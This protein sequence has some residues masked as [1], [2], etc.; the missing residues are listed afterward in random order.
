MTLTA[1]LLLSA[2]IAAAQPAPE[3]KAL[4]DLNAAFRKAYAGAKQRMLA[5]TGPLI[6]A[7]GDTAVLVRNGSRQEA[8][9][10]AP[11]YHTVKAIAHVPLAIFVALTPGEGPLPADRRATLTELRSLIPPARASLDT[12]K[13]PP[14]TIVRQDRITAQS[15]A[16]IDDILATGR[17]TRA[18]L[19]SY[20]KKMAPLV[21]ENAADATRAE[22]DVLH[23]QVMAWRKAMTAE[24]WS[25]LKVL[26]VGPHMPREGLAAMQYFSK[27]LNEP[28]EGRR[29]VYAESLWEE[30]RALDLLGTH[31]LDGAVGE[32]FFG[33][34]WRM[35]RD[36]LAD[37][38]KDYLDGLAAR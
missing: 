3:S 9:V 12:L 35:H 11:S 19:E 31:M 29:I 21:L 7:N 4:V 28:Q 1:L 13:M 10:N 23:A 37:A 16:F 15:M 34:F 22:L 8:V 24:E 26:V 14:A 18:A 2:G 27:V 30:P 25:K 38:A 36:L 5:D 17:Y 33:D 32:A 20:T 6:V